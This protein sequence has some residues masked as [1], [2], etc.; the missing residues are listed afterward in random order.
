MFTNTR[1]ATV[2]TVTLR[3][4]R[5]QRRWAVVLLA[6][7]AL[8]L[9]IAGTSRADTPAT[10][11]I[12]LNTAYWSGSAGFGTIAPT[13]YLDGNGL[14]HLLGAAKGPPPCPPRLYCPPDPNLL[15]SLPGGR[16]GPYTPNRDVYTIVHTNYGTYA[17]LVIK[18]DGSIYLLPPRSPAVKDF[19]FVSLEGISYQPISFPT[20]SIKLNGFNWSSTTGFATVAPAF[21]TDPDGFVH[22]EGAA[23]QTSTSLDANL[24]GTLPSSAA[25]P[26][27]V[28]TIAHTSFGTYAD[29]VIQT[30]GEIRMIGARPPAVQDY[31]FVSLEGISYDTKP[32]LGAR[33][34]ESTQW[35][36]AG[37][38]TATPGSRQD[39]AGF[40][41]L[42]G[43]VTQL[44]C[45]SEDPNLVGWLSPELPRPSHN[46]FTIADTNFGTYVDVSIL[47]D[48]SIH[49][50]GS[51]RPPAVTDLS[52]LSLEGIT[53]QH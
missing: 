9:V 43:A 22:L 11:P 17:D 50:T 3:V 23:K 26:H 4:S 7:G 37:F 14:V 8:F 25:P 16:W 1:A 19:A 34:G 18:T 51:A 29:V 40:V 15:G 20:G 36:D 5:A 49:V 52:F 42:E 21:Y 32:W 27:N 44:G 10:A 28:Y 2:A 48:G 38:D 33:L 12:T 41:H 13:A 45:C 31:S 39:S 35:S 24:L 47:T 46:V 6:A 30:N 53:Y